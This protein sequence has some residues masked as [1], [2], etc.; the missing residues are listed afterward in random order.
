MEL[1]PMLKTGKTPVSRS[2]SVIS[3]FFLPSMTNYSKFLLAVCTH[4]VLL[5]AFTLLIVFEAHPV[6]LLIFGVEVAMSGI[7]VCATASNL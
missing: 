7:F 6:L 1:Q 3:P 2:L 5:L 4:L